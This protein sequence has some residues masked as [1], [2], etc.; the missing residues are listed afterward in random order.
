[1]R[2]A[3]DPLQIMQRETTDHFRIAA[4]YDIFAIQRQIYIRRGDKQCIEQMSHTVSS[5]YRCR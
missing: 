1:M 4:D 3:Y 5:I 2:K